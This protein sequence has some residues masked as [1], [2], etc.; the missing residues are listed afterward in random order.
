ML[1]LLGLSVFLERIFT[2]LLNVNER[3]DEDSLVEVLFTH[4]QT[5]T[6]R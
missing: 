4:M 2:H 3:Y 1:F 6:E 5:N